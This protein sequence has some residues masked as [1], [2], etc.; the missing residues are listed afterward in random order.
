[1]TD[2]DNI[3]VLL[4]D[5]SDTDR[6]SVFREIYNVF[7][8]LE[9]KT[10]REA[11]NIVKHSKPACV[12]LDYRLPD[13]DGL[14]LLEQF[15]EQQI[16]VVMLTGQGNEELAAR[17][18]KMG[19]ED[20]L[21]KSMLTKETLIRAVANAIE[22]FNLRKKLDDQEQDVADFVDF[23]SDEMKSPL[24]NI[25][26][27]AE[28]HRQQTPESQD[29]N[30]L[31]LENVAQ[32]NALIDAMVEYTRVGR[33]SSELIPVDLEKCVDNAVNAMQVEI[34]AAGATVHCGRM[35]MVEGNATA[36]SEVFQNLI[37]SAL[38]TAATPQPQVRISSEIS[39]EIWTILVTNSGIDT[40]VHPS[41]DALEGPQ[42]Q[43]QTFGRLGLAICAKIIKQHGGKI[44]TDSDQNVKTINFTLPK[45]QI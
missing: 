24:Q 11:V 39:N 1:M 30:K 3:R 35:P 22:K 19:A 20:Y 23:V 26:K 33:L 2:Q 6:E 28:A 27:A 8:V 16:P 17:A 15:V 12:L 41:G 40:E 9:A 37:R 42:T 14:D 29:G 43:H 34:D 5:D 21:S 38:K 25:A 13:F 7:C 10:G 44:W 32:L 31:I 45:S 4:V 36:L 18:I